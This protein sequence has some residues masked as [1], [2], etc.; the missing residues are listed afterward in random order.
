MDG[1][2][3]DSETAFKRG[4]E[5]GQV[6]ARL[7][8]HDRHFTVINGNIARLGDEM[9]TLVQDFRAARTEDKTRNAT[10]VAA[11][12]ALKQSEVDRRELAEAKWDRFQRLFAVL[13]GVAAA[14]TVVSVLY[15]FAH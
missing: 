13:A 4:Q 15:S 12:E 14:I 5:A 3:E 8:E 11:A 9:H 10:T 7:D 6:I 1:P 2:E